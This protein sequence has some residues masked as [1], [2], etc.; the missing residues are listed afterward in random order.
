MTRLMC[1]YRSA[2]M[3]TKKA[4]NHNQLVFVATRPPHKSR[5]I[6]KR[7]PEFHDIPDDFKDSVD[8][9]KAVTNVNTEAYLQKEHRKSPLMPRY[10]SKP[11]D[12]ESSLTQ[13]QDHD[14][15]LV[16]ERELL[17]PYKNDEFD[18]KS[19]DRLADPQK[20]LNASQ[21][22]AAET[23]NHA[24]SKTR[25]KRSSQADTN[26]D[27]F[28]DSAD[29]EQEVTNANT[30]VY[31]QEEGQIPSFTPRYLSKRQGDDS[32][33]GQ[34]PDNDP[35]MEISEYEAENEKELNSARSKQ[36]RY[37]GDFDRDEYANFEQEAMDLGTP[38]PPPTR[39][40]SFLERRGQALLARLRARD[41]KRNQIKMIPKKRPHA[42]TE[43]V[44]VEEEVNFPP[45]QER[46]KLAILIGKCDR[47][48]ECSLHAQ[49][50][51]RTRRRPGF[52]RCLPT[53]EGNGIFCWEGG[54]WM[55]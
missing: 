36:K 27:Y 40:L 53:F 4:R 15:L 14:I 37:F 52:C 3:V 51:K 12:D 55:I 26:P 29:S 17:D 41:S 8:D 43:M 22:A 46:D 13:E 33:S 30:D 34:E 19:H 1:T 44:D 10:L 18:D 48:A 54:K 2:H 42:T 16:V 31:V 45:L 28:K 11:Q 24:I 6:K 50:V 35:S 47:D 5:N 23:L 7:S 39:R 38:K 21:A 20:Q 32:S 25:K 9:E 49:C